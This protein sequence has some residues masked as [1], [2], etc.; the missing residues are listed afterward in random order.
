VSRDNGKPRKF[1]I[2]MEFDNLWQ[3]TA[4]QV[5]RS[6]THFESAASASSAIP[7]QGG[8]IKVSH[9]HSRPLPARSQYASTANVADV[10]Q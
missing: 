7:A 3:L 8:Q 9:R 10:R 2:S 6:K 1:M 5:E 4:F